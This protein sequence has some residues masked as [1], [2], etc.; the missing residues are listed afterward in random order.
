MFSLSSDPLGTAVRVEH[1]IDIG[2]AKPF[3]ISPYKIA[4]D[5]LESVREEIHEMLD[6]GVV[7]PSKSPFSSPIVIVP[8]KDG[9]N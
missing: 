8:T 7:V 9:S 4:P 5:K 6:K 1:H 2:D 3:K